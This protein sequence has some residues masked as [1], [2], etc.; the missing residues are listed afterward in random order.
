M[1]DMQFP[2]SSPFWF[3]SVSR[4]YGASDSCHGV[5]SF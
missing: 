5:S 2:V 4:R 1:V 3:S